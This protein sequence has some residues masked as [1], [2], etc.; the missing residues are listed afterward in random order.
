MGTAPK[1][2]EI[3]KLSTHRTRCFSVSF[4]LLVFVQ[5]T[6]V[7]A[8]ASEADVH[9]GL[10]YWL[11]R[12]AGFEKKYAE[13]VAAG[14]YGADQGRY[15]PAPWVVALHIILDGDVGAANAVRNTH[16][17]SFQTL[18]APPPKRAVEPNSPAARRAAENSVKAPD[19]KE[20]LDFSLETLGF[21]LHPLQDSWA[22]QGVPDIPFRP[23]YQRHPE[24][25]FGHPAD[26]GGW[27]LHNAD[28]TCLDDHPKEVV[29][30]AKASYEFMV[31]FLK[32]HPTARAQKSA[33]WAVL[34]PRVL[35][36]AKACTKGQ[37]LRWFKSDENVP[38][39]D[40]G[41]QNFLQTISTPGIISRIGGALAPAP[42]EK[43][44]YVWKNLRP[45]F[46]SAEAKDTIQRFFDN[47]LVKQDIPAALQ[48]LDLQALAAQEFRTSE[49]SLGKNVGA[50][51]GMESQNGEKDAK[52]EAAVRTWAEKFLVLWLVEDHGLVNQMGHGIPLAKEYESLPSDT[53]KLSDSFRLVSYKSLDDAIYAPES[54]E[55]NELPY[56]VGEGFSP[57]IP[58][59]QTAVVAFQFRRL[60]NDTLLLFFSR[61]AKGWQ[62]SRMYWVVI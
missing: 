43:R 22:H 21:A 49:P 4:V 2:G 47:W 39:S 26:R 48:F 37:K 6:L 35:E 3:V 59:G 10:T 16:F 36:F 56:F 25:S 29:A 32:T 55:K 54:V 61:T 40:Y 8:T 51:L 5:S 12:Q 30:A 15:N 34:E 60:P 17:A 41:D 14:D 13:K 53:K 11:A 50:E 9:Y 27:F 28:I 20:P 58:S 24:L 42:K 44:E 46:L 33:D 38:L 18:P 19:P 45:A 57:D 23:G 1:A 62:V 52:L 7:P 31:E